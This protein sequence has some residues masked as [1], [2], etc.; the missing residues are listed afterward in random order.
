M[1]GAASSGTQ[2]RYRVLRRLGV[3]GM[4]E[5]FVAEREGPGGFVQRVC[6]KRILPAFANDAEFVRLFLQEARLA[7]RLRHN[8]IVGVL[9]FGREESGYFLAL[10]LIEGADLRKL[11]RTHPEHRLP[12]PVAVLIAGDVALALEYAHALGGE[13]IVHR[14]IS[15]SNILLSQAGE[16]KLGDFGIAKAMQGAGAT[17]TNSLK[18]KIP[19]M[20]PEQM[21]M[22]DIDG[23]SDLFALG[24]VLYEMLTGR[25]PFDGS[26]DVQTMTRI[27]QGEREPIRRLRPDV[28]P[29][30]VRIVDRLLHPDRD[31]RYRDAGDLLDALSPLLPSAA[32]RRQL[33]R[34]VSE[35]AEAPD[36]APPEA[37]GARCSEA[38]NSAEP[39]S[40][41]NVRTAHPTPSAKP[42][43][44]AVEPLPTQAES[45]PT[46]ADVSASPTV[47]VEPP[48]AVQQ[49]PLERHE[50][51]SASPEAATRTRLPAAEMQPPPSSPSTAPASPGPRSVAKAPPRIRNRKATLP[52]QALVGE[53]GVQAHER[54]LQ[55]ATEATT[56]TEPTAPRPSET[57]PS[58]PSPLPSPAPSPEPSTIQVDESLLAT[59]EIEPSAQDE[60]A[61]PAWMRLHLLA[62]VALLVLVSLGGG[63]YV[64]FVPDEHQNDRP[65]APPSSPA[66]RAATATRPSHEEPSSESTVRRITKSPSKNAPQAPPPAAPSPSPSAE[67][68][69]AHETS[70]P[71]NRPGAS[72]STPR[73]E[74][75]PEPNPSPRPAAQAPRRA[76]ATP[77]G[78]AVREEARYR[79]V[80]RIPSGAPSGKLAIRCIPWGD[81]W[82]DGIPVG[83]SPVY[84]RVRA[85][86]RRIE[87]GQGTGRVTRTVRV[88]E[89]SRRRIEIDLTG[90]P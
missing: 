87:C 65:A 56:P 74:R 61:R 22:T 86:N 30:L 77:R 25:R 34:M 11:L 2:G 13:G 49:P 19:Y 52:L 55:R 24:V 33:A 15:P 20:A 47:A 53:A 88:R 35:A 4:A 79:V 1:E 10:E 5:T 72:P 44:E 58:P 50:P 70:K 69:P 51:Q 81:V 23:R 8:N 67:A 63:L 64:A 82:V 59:A 3:G 41:S 66:S 80:G 31:R 38:A 28:P 83:R 40:V 7:A 71:S 16:V 27:M 39:R 6:L 78:E 76:K 45:A 90:G 18:G 54:A 36:A 14:D 89:G 84:V 68:P 75:A 9:D 29:P 85:G 43:E 62:P 57:P 21:R 32:T 26:T 37:T 73:H 46:I 12:I 17:A 48:P 60:P 42:G